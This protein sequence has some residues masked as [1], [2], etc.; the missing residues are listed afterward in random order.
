MEEQVLFNSAGSAGYV[1]G[2]AVGD[3]QRYESEVRAYFRASHADIL[4]GIRTSGKLPECD[5]LADALAKFTDTFDT[6]KVD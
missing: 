3:V 5:V 1:D 2:I 6:G 4:E